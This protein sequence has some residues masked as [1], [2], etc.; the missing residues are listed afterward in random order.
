MSL[1]QYLQ[2]TESLKPT[3]R[4]VDQA[5]MKNQAEV[6]WRIW[7]SLSQR[8]MVVQRPDPSESERK[9]VKPVNFR[10]HKSK[11]QRPN[12]KSTEEY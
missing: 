11:T 7:A 10:G 2:D 9:L 3:C 12:F 5:M 4:N 6:A 1:V 8:A